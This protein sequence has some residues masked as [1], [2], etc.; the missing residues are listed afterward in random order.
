MVVIVQNGDKTLRK[1]SKEVPILDIKKPKIQQIIKDMSDA[2]D[3]QY[4]G[5]AIAAPQIGVSLRIFVVSGKIFDENFVRGEKPNGKNSYDKKQW[6]NLVFINP[7]FKKISKDRKLMTEGCLSVR[8][9][10]G[11]VRRAT[12][13]TIEAYD[14]HGKKFVQEGAGLLAHIFQHETDHLDGILFIDKAKNLQEVFNE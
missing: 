12:R 10:Y 13:A 2:L 4:D 7:V 3:S 11:K 1:I 14:E 5:V 6:P 8:P 9:L